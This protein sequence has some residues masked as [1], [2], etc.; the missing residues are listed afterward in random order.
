MSDTPFFD[1]FESRDSETQVQRR[2]IENVNIGEYASAQADLD[3]LNRVEPSKTPQPKV[4]AA[5][6][7]A[8]V[9][10]ALGTVVTWI[11]EASAGIDIPAGVELAIGVILTAGLAFVGGY[12]KKN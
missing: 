9:G 12:W 8:G 2:I 7:G 11:V 4:V 6:A 10:V 5:T 1:E 3:V